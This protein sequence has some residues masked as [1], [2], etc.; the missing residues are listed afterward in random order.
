[1]A[2]ALLTLGNSLGSTFV[3]LHLLPPLLAVLTSRPR[4]SSMPA[5]AEMR[6]NSF[7][8]AGMLCFHEL[9]SCLPLDV[10]H[11]LKCLSLG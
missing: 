2:I 9:P 7:S 8:R 10:A 4:S 3:A 1:M 11:L 6:S 5:A